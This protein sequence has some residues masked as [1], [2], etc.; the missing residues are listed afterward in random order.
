MELEK[1]LTLQAPP[2][3]VWALLLDPGVMAAC[4]PGMQS[5]EVLS[6]ISYRARMEVKIAFIT[7]RFTLLTNVVEQRPPHYLRSE[8]TGEDK[9]VASSLKQTS[10][11]FLDAREDGGTELRM[12]VR[13]DVFGRLGSFGLSAMKTKADRLW[14]AFGEAFAARLAGASVS[15]RAGPQ[16]AVA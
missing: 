10:E 16:Q 12:K 1:S 6:E 4:V 8:G 13:V 7:A 3:Q 9:S 2:A 11:M 5:I 14:Q 15:G